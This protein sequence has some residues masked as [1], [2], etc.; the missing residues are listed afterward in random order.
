MCQGGNPLIYGS[1]YKVGANKEMDAWWL[2]FRNDVCRGL[3]FRAGMTV[4]EV[5]RLIDENGKQIDTIRKEQNANDTAGNFS[6]NKFMMNLYEVYDNHFLYSPF[7]ESELHNGTGRLSLLVNG[8]QQF[9][10]DMAVENGR[11]KNIYLVPGNLN[12]IFPMA[13]LFDGSGRPVGLALARYESEV[14][15]VHNAPQ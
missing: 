15:C 10:V 13:V 4:A 12:M 9:Y 2:K 5:Q 1:Y 11:V 7:D 14:G 6:R 8:M 3:P